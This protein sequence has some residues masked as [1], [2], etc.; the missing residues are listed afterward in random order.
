MT[1]ISYQNIFDWRVLKKWDL[2]NS[3]ALPSD[4]IYY[5]KE[6]DFLAEY[7]WYILAGILF[8]VLETF[9][10]V[11]LYKLNVRQKAIVR[12]KIEAENLYRIIVREERLMMMVELTASLS[13]E[14]SQ[15]LTAILYNAQACLR[16]L[17][18]EKP[19]PGQIEEIL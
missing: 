5:Y 7:K 3:K 14:L 1:I 18:L 19:E 10:I 11:Y 15:P 9:L 2:L 17:K 12:Q 16:F 6:Y 8:L 13:H 4:S